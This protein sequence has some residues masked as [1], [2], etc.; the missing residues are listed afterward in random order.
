MNENGH[1]DGFS[2]TIGSNRA[3]GA[4]GGIKNAGTLNLVDV[5]ISGN[6]SDQG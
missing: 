5:T 6:V 1:L 3:V 2:S 4:G